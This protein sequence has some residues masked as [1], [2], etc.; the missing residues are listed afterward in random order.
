MALQMCP[1]AF[2]IS[3]LVISCMARFAYVSSNDIFLSFFAGFG[4]DAVN[5]AEKGRRFKVVNKANR[6]GYEEKTSKETERL[7]YSQEAF[8][9][10][11]KV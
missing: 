5:I 1:N 9:L 6:G 11:C 2:S 3:G 8:V 4:L 10:R 7:S